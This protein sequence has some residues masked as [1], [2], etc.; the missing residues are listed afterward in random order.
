MAG[1]AGGAALSVYGVELF[2]TRVRAAA[3]VVLVIITVLGSGAGLVAAG[4]LS[5][6]LGLGPAIAVLV[7]AP[8]AGAVVVVLGFPETVGRDLDETSGEGIVT[9][10]RLSM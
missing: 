2:P 3:N 7:I 10:R 6:A 9:I 4:V 5:G 1:S 8:L